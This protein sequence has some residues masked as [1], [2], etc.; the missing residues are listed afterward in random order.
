[1]TTPATLTPA[2]EIFLRRVALTME[3]TGLSIEDAMRAVLQRDEELYLLKVTWPEE[4]KALVHEIAKAIYD[5][6]R[7]GVTG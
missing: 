1:M 7:K 5:D 2:E 6:V 4:W 3:G